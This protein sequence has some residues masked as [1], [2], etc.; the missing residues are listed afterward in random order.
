MADIDKLK[1]ELNAEVLH[2]QELERR[3]DASRNTVTGLQTENANLLQAK[4]VDAGMLKRRDRMI[5]DMKA[6]LEGERA[7]RE[8]AEKSASQSAQ[9]RE[10]AVTTSTRQTAEAREIAKHATTHAEVLERSHK[11]L[12]TEYRLRVD[13][14]A[15]DLGKIEQDR[16]EDKQK[17]KRLDVVVEQMGQELDKANKTNGRI[18]ETYD[19]YRDES[20]R[21]LKTMQ[22]RQEAG[23]AAEAGMR[24]EAERIMGEARYL[25][26]LGKNVQERATAS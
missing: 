22:A 14:M 10:E 16:E 23:E 24:K 11:Q 8:A 26:N 19:S 12:G 9:E 13:K 17:V 25:I 4:E 1:R 2:R 6:E 21:R 15:N 3:E 5:A 7:R 18:R 20:E